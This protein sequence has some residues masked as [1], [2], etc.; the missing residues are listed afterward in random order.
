MPTSLDTFAEPEAPDA[1]AAP[2]REQV[3]A[4]GHLTTARRPRP[5]HRSSALGVGLLK[6]QERREICEARALVRRF[7]GW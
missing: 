6:A 3:P 2:R 7:Y 1:Q 4:A 5:G